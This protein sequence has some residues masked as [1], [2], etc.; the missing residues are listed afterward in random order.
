MEQTKSNLPNRWLVFVVAVIGSICVA[1]SQFKVT[2][3]M[4]FIKDDYGIDVTMAGMLISIVAL[5]NLLTALPGGSIVSKFGVRRVWLFGLAWC[6]VFNIL[7][8]FAPDFVTLA[9][10]RFCEG[11]SVGF[12]F[13][14]APVIIT[15]AFPAEKRGLPM[16]LWSIWSTM[17][18]LLAL[19]L[20]NI[21]TPLYGWHAIWLASAA[22]LVIA[23]IL[24]LLFCK[25]ASDQDKARSNAA[26]KKGGA[27][28]RKSGWGE[29]LKNPACMCI[30]IVFFA[31]IFAFNVYMSYYPTFLQ[32]TL[33]IPS[34]EANSVSTVHTYWMIFLCLTFG[35]AL[36]K[37]ENRHHPKIFF[38]LTFFSV[39][40]GVLMWNLPSIPLDI[41]A[42]LLCGTGM[43]LIG[44]MAHNL[45]PDAVPPH[46]VPVSMGLLSFF[47][48]LA[49]MLG[50][51]V[52][53]PV[54]DLTGN[55]GLIAI[56]V[57]IVG[58]V[59]IIAGAVVLKKMY[60]NDVEKPAGEAPAAEKGATA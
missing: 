11:I 16:T 50:P 7:G 40:G 6:F 35:F 28:K 30:C 44:P 21:L 1:V 22:L 34:A 52:C 9:V 46:A 31:A 59:G 27:P 10:T 17:G 60:R 55:W 15:E 45:A 25:V 23:F 41:V 24:N 13:I 18:T 3:T 42:I 12:V 2:G 43:Q 36:N 48:G 8:F 32:S 38:V 33:G 51:V 58:V 29:C 26:A 4:S 47:S 37:I 14:V 56:P 57:G 49:A 54:V 19:N 39:V 20:C 53:G 5:A